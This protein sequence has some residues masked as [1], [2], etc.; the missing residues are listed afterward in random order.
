M[1][2]K[3]PQIELQDEVL[4]IGVVNKK[5]ES[6]KFLNLPLFLFWEFLV[7]TCCIFSFSSVPVHV[8]FWFELS[9][10]G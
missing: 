10:L 7:Q 3:S 6:G 2:I 8:E 5:F 9:A 1:H 4:G